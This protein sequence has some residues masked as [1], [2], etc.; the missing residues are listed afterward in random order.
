[1]PNQP[2]RHPSKVADKLLELIPNEPDTRALI[3]QLTKLSYDGEFKAPE[4][5][6]EL[7]QRGTALLHKYLPSPNGLTKQW[8]VEVVNT[9]IGSERYKVKETKDGD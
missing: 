1:M 6:G 9:W 4:Q 2:S 8:Q 7:W 5:L 3:F